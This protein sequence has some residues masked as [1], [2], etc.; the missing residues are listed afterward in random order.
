MLHVDVVADLLVHVV[1]GVLERFLRDDAAAA[2]D[3]QLYQS[4]THVDDVVWV[5]GEDVEAAARGGGDRTF[6]DKDGAAAGF[7]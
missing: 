7:P 1:T 5:V 4:G 3:A 2:D 6:Q